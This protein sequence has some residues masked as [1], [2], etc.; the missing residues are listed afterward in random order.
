[1]IMASPKGSVL[2]ADD[3]SKKFDLDF[4]LRP[5]ACTCLLCEGLAWIFPTQKTTEKG[6]VLCPCAEDYVGFFG[7]AMGHIQEEREEAGLE[8]FTLETW[9]AW[10][11]SEIASWSKGRQSEAS[12]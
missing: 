4:F 6:I 12:A 2:R 8:L 7:Q 1:M 10:R 11:D 5:R 3:S 9:E